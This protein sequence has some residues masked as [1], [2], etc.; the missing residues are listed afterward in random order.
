ETPRAPTAEV[1]TASVDPEPMLVSGSKAA[2]PN[3]AASQRE[4]DSATAEKIA[5][6]SPGPCSPSAQM[7]R[8]ERKS[9][10]A[11]EKLGL[12]AVKGVFRMTVKTS[13]GVVFVVKAPDVFKQ[14]RKVNVHG[15]S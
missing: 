9:R 3:G 1:E 2:A 8:A 12:R 11:M 4:K 5:A 14:P 6:P 7:N 10:Q 13:N 15:A